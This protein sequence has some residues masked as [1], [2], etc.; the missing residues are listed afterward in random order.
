MMRSKVYLALQAKKICAF[1]LAALLCATACAAAAEPSVPFIRM[2]RDN[3]DAWLE[4]LDN[5]RFVKDSLFAFR[6][7]NQKYGIDPEYHPDT[8][9][10]DTL[11]ISGSA[12]FSI[13]QFRTLADSLRSCAAGRTVYIIDLRQESHVL[14]N[15]GISLSWYGSHNW[16]NAGMTAAEAETDEVTR[17]G[18][19]IGSTVSAFARENDTPINETEI[20]IRSVM[21]ER[22]LVESEGFVYVRLP[23]QDHTWPTPEEI[24]YFILLV[25]DLDPDQIWLHF[26]CQAGKGRTG[27]MMMIYDMIRN[28]D[29]A[30]KDIVIRQTMLGG[31]YPLYTENS[32]SYKVPLYAEKARMTP[33]FYAY[34]QEE[35]I[36]GFTVLWSDWLAATEADVTKME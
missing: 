33:L 1:L 8:K 21:T 17:F 34:V 35:H 26:H 19:M 15:E 36:G 25:R 29:V 16:A 4:K 24:D 22:K 18:G 20:L 9:G 32:D 3:P 5:V 10:L 27:I 14:V 31:S 7:V 13:P 6:N 11:C 28:P 12:Q 2:D 23:I 30:M